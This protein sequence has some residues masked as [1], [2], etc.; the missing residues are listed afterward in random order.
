MGIDERIRE[1]IF[2]EMKRRKISKE[3]LAEVMGCHCN[4]V[5]AW[6]RG[7]KMTLDMADRALKAL[8]LSAEIGDE[9]E[10]APKWFG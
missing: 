1:Q 3:R 7:G 5:Y 2:S 8:G 10:K 6:S 9:E 4:S